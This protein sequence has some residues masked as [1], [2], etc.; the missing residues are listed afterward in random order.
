MITLNDINY[1]LPEDLIATHPSSEIGGSRLLLVSRKEKSIIDSKFQ[2]IENMIKPGDCLVMNNTKVFK[3]RLY[4]R[5]REDK[6]VEILLVEHVD[7]MRWLAM[8]KN[9]KKIEEGTNVHFKDVEAEILEKFEDMRIIRF[10]EPQ[11]F[12]QI[13]NIGEVPLPPYI[14]KK[15]KKNSESIYSK[16]D[17]LRYQSLVAKYYGSVAAPTASL[18][19]T[20]DL[21]KNLKNRGIEVVYIT[22]H[23]GPGTF[24]P[25]DTEIIDDYRIHKEFMEVPDETINILQKTR[26]SGGRIIAVGTTVVRALETMALPY[27]DYTLWKSFKGTTGLFIRN[28]FNFKVTNALITNFHIPK[29]SLLLLIL[30]FGGKELI[31]KSYDHAIL[32]KYCFLSYGDAMFIY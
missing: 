5:T 25:I 14:I 6:V 8:V 19:F 1:K 12:E 26:R 20:N 29:S 32:N 21:L 23:V 13:N 3:A 30:S 10:L 31:R 15:R 18:H 2:Q 11:T 24:K 9:S 22:L 17:E 28:E 16:E 4:G 7:D 27:G